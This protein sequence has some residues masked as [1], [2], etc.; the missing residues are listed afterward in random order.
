MT[1]AMVND[2]WAEVLHDHDIWPGR[3]EAVL[4]GGSPSGSKVCRSK[5]GQTGRQQGP[6]DATSFACH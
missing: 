4:V 6:G 5:G 2:N 1:L 3:S